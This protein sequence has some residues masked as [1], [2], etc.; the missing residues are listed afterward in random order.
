[1]QEQHVDN[2][3]KMGK[4]MVS[5][6]KEKG[7]YDEFVDRLIEQGHEHPKEINFE[8]LNFDGRGMA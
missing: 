6:L 5:F 4:L 2:V 7:I 1:M 8:K 3:M